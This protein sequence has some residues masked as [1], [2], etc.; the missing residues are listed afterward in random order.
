MR[1]DNSGKSSRWWVRIEFVW[2]SQSTLCFQSALR[3]HKPWHTLQFGSFPLYVLPQRP[4]NST[5]GLSNSPCKTR[6]CTPSTSRWLQIIQKKTVWKPAWLYSCTPA[7]IIVSL[8][9]ADMFSLSKYEVCGE[10]TEHAVH[11]LTAMLCLEAVW[12]WPK[13]WPWM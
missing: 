5:A 3:C 13:R 2:P 7:F 8:K 1:E 11:M 12:K 6:W 10:I 9:E 4:H